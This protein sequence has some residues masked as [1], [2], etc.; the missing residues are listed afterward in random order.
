MLHPTSCY[1][2]KRL[3]MLGVDPQRL[4]HSSLW[5]ILIGKAVMANSYRIFGLSSLSHAEL[6]T[7]P[8]PCWGTG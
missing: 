1:G 7:D 3:K 4:L 2:R 5:V 6:C 8:G